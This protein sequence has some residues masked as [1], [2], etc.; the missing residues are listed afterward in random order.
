MG[1]EAAGA[2][3]VQR[4]WLDTWALIVPML[5]LFV[6]FFAGPLLLLVVAS[7]LDESLGGPVRL[8]NWVKFLSD[9]YNLGAVFRTL[10]LGLAIVLTTLLF[11]YPLALVARFGPKWLGR[12][13]VLSALLPFLTSVV[14]RSFAWIA[15]LSRDGALNAL[16]M[17]LGLTSEPL[18]LLPSEL[19][20]VLALTQIEIPLMLLPIL[21]TLRRIDQRLIEASE[22]LGASTWRVLTRVVLPMSLP[23][24]LAGS[25]FVFSSAVTAFVSQSIIGGSRVVY[26]TSIIYSNAMITFDWG[27]ASVAA[28]IL[29]FSAGA[30]IAFALVVGGRA[31]RAIYG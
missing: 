29:L 21:V 26:L 14:V 8:A 24:L 12:V 15:I 10:R 20:L 23:G 2:G 1:T 4:D 25:V 27:M 3:R 6:L 18:R 11:A 9:S 5:L 22:A 19:G 28:L 16:L 17:A 7:L 13:I 31:E 30:V